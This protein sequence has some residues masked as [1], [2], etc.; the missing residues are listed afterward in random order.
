MNDFKKKLMDY[1][2]M[3]SKTMEKQMHPI[4][5]QQLDSKNQFKSRIR[6]YNC[7]EEEHLTKE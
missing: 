4:N 3:R 5:I 1:E 2:N 7:H 6:C